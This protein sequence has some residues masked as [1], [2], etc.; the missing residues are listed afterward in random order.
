MFYREIADTDT[1]PLLTSDLSLHFSQITVHQAFVWAQWHFWGHT[2]VQSPHTPHSWNVHFPLPS[3]WIGTLKTSPHLHLLQPHLQWPQPGCSSHWAIHPQQPLTSFTVWKCIKWV[4]CLFSNNWLCRP[5]FDRSPGCLAICSAHV[6]APREPSAG[7]GQGTK[8]P[9]LW[10]L[11]YSP[12]KNPMEA[13]VYCVRALELSKREIIHSNGPIQLMLSFF[14]EFP[15][16]AF[17]WRDKT[18]RKF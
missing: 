10:A 15:V 14:I 3:A 18:I 5:W 17:V 12:P 9:L 1:S 4:N 2:E 16:Y 8:H 13:L 11:A 6:A 7:R